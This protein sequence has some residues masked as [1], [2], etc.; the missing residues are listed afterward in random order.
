MTHAIETP[1][2]F[3]ENLATE[4]GYLVSSAGA[5]ELIRDRDAA[6]RADE[7]ARCVAELREFVERSRR[8]E[9]LGK[10]GAI[11]VSMRSGK[12]QMMA[13]ELAIV[14]L[15]TAADRLESKGGGDG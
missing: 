14:A 10:A 12:T 15:M 4:H 3:L 13:E 9:A 7:R 2:E 1:D 8:G 11:L 5:L 6:I